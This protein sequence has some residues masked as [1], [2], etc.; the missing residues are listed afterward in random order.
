MT[1]VILKLLFMPDEDCI[2][3]VQLGIYGCKYLLPSLAVLV[4]D[5]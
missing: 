3:K 1:A 5:K 4:N 2:L